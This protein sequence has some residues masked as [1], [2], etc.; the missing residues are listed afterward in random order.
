MVNNRKID[1]ASAH[2]TSEIFAM[3]LLAEAALG[4]TATPE[5]VTALMGL[6]TSMTRFLMVEAL[7]RA[8]EDNSES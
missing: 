3:R 1:E 2:M 7:D 8:Q 4:P 6:V 5:Q